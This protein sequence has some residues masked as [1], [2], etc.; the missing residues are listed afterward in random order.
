MGFAD[1][2]A[3]LIV[4]VIAV[5]MAALS[6]NFGYGRAES[7]YLAEMNA[8]QKAN[9]AAIATAV[10]ELN[11]DLAKAQI[12]NERLDDAYDQLVKDARADADADECGVSADGVRRL[13]TIR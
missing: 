1:K 9:D 4:V 7:K 8:I 10:E 5:A 3:T 11:E 12:E 6:Y 2:I 13:N